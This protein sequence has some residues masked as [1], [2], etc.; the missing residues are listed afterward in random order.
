MEIILLQRVESLGEMGE[1]VRVKDG[2]ARNYLLPQSLALRANAENR[3]KFEHQR[4]DLEKAN[5]D[6]RSAAELVSSDLDGTTCVLIRQ[7]SEAGQLYGSVTAADVAEAVSNDA[8]TVARRQVKLDKPIKTLGVHAVRVFLHPEV[9]AVVQI[10]VARTE[11][12]AE[13]QLKTGNADVDGD[14]QEAD[15]AAEAQEASED[16]FE[17]GAGPESLDGDESDEGDAET[18]AS[19]APEADKAE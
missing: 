19:A 9:P 6:R 16:F 14:S 10:V 4:K 2:F 18:E 7:A 13:S 11:E 3:E 1:V 17:E 12:E 15:S 8:T 5:A